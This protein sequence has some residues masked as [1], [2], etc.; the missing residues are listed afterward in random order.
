MAYIQYLDEQTKA[1][2]DYYN[3]SVNYEKPWSEQNDNHSIVGA[4]VV[5]HTNQIVQTVAIIGGIAFMVAI[6]VDSVGAVAFAVG[7]GATYDG[8]GTV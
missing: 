1:Y 4:W 8:D 3:E 5:E 7:V 2:S 6:V